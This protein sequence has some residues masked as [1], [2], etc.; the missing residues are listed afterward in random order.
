MELM[1]CLVPLFLSLLQPAAGLVPRS[2]IKSCGRPAFRERVS[3]WAEKTST[4]ASSPLEALSAKTTLA[5]AASG[6]LLG[7]FLDNY[8]SDFGQSC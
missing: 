4:E 6:A 3:V 5:N 8:H 7:P 2:V 1:R